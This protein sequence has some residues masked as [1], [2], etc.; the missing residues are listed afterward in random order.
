[1]CEICLETD[2]H[3]DELGQV[4][5]RGTAL[6]QREQMDREILGWAL[7]L[8][9][10]EIAYPTMLPLRELQKMDYLHAFPHLA[11]FATTLSDKDE[12]L[13]QR[14]AHH[15]DSNVVAHDELLDT[16]VIM[17][18]AAC[19]HVYIHEQNKQLDRN[20]YITTRNTCFRREKGYSSLQRQWSFSMRE[21]VYL[22]N[23]TAVSAFLQSLKDRINQY[24]AEL[25]IQAN[26]QQATDPFFNAEQNDKYIAQT[27]FPIKQELVLENGLAIASLN[28][29]GQYFGET[30][31]IRHGEAPAYSACVAFGLE[32]WLYALQQTGGAQ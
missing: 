29:H 12:V 5:L 21:I 2:V 19:Y 25:G 27:I 24:I 18:P 9:A 8:G 15:P 32:R 1:M 20:K 7:E 3:A 17:T 10:E 30:Y 23:E 16:E 31:G 26:W 28:N 11:T 14:S 13:Q 4:I 6:Q 22:G